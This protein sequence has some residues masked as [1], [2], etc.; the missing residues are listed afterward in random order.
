M[1]WMYL[2]YFFLAL[3]LFFGAKGAGQGKW[4]EG[5]TSL[6]Q[7]KM[8]Q[9]ATAL[10]IALHHMAQKSCAPWH[11]RTYIVHGLDPFVPMGYMFVGV[12]L[13]C[14]GLGLYKSL[15]SKPDYLKGFFRR[16]VAPII[17]AFYL[18]EWIYLV[19]RLLMGEKMDT[20]QILWYL[21]GLQMANFNSW[22]VIVIP[23]FYLVFWAAFRF[24]R[25]EGT[26]IFLV[27]LFTLGYTVL[28]ACIDHQNV[29]WMRG[30]WWYNSIILFPLGILFAKHETAVTR[31]FRR[32]YWF[33]LIFIFAAFFALYQGSEYMINT[34]WGYYGEWGDPLK[35]THRLLSAGSQWL[36][37][38]AYVGF[39]FLLMMKVR[40]G[41]GLLAWLGAFSLAFYLMHGMFV[42]MWGYNFLDLTKSIYYIKNVPLYIA[43]VLGCAV[44]ATLMF[45]WIW[46]KAVHPLRRERI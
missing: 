15:K 31:F 38:I 10:G 4:N 27:F 44:P 25:R 45:S 23:F 8:L 19:V 33:W 20:A 36:V 26:A 16:R 2:V 39:C 46:K 14:S 35:V 5:Y 24:C 40:L 6:G 21:S 18:S 3:T 41:N 34:R 11:P 13:F 30:E 28:G 32:G 1:D 9:G 7:C 22:Y 29:W 43:A 12:F 37:A 17:I 42:E